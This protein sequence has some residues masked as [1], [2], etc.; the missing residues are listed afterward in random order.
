VRDASRSL[1][2]LVEPAPALAAGQASLLAAD[3]FQVRIC[4]SVGGIARACAQGE[5]GLALV[6]YDELIFTQ[7]PLNANLL[8]ELASVVPI[9]LITSSEAEATAGPCHV[10]ADAFADLDRLRAAAHQLAPRLQGS[11][12]VLGGTFQVLPADS[13][14][15]G[16]RSEQSRQAWQAH[17][18]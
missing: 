3:G 5:R 8:L 15:I 14:A 6:D 18:D 9:L 17:A 11:P 13:G 12:P 4:A 7:G 2:W 1:I 10:L 16:F